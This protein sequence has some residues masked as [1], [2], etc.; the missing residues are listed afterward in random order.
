MTDVRGAMPGAKPGYPPPFRFRLIVISFGVLMFV[1][2]LARLIRKWLGTTKPTAL[3]VDEFRQALKRAIEL[4]GDFWTSSGI[5]DVVLTDI[6][7]A[8]SI[9]DPWQAMKAFLLRNDRDSPLR[10]LLP[11]H[12]MSTIVVSDRSETAFQQDD[13]TDNYVSTWSR[14]G[15]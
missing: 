2:G 10:L 4:D 12:V 3:T 11:Q 14:K 8:T 5:V 13:E 7:T 6:Q 15:G 9:E 1:L